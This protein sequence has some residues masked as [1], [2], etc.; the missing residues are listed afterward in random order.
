M[1]RMLAISVSEIS[2]LRPQCPLLATQKHC[3]FKIAFFNHSSKFYNPIWA[4][5]RV[6]FVC[7]LPSCYTRAPWASWRSLR[8]GTFWARAHGRT[9][10]LPQS[11]PA[12]GHP[13]T[14]SEKKN[15]RQDEDKDTNVCIRIFRI[16]QNTRAALIM[17][18]DVSLILL[19][20]YYITEV[21]DK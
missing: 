17:K 15:R 8:S 9:S 19:Y 5:M 16:F 18:S 7:E 14:S 4:H 3:T 21:K 2:N 1:I 13:S 20:C 11:Q 6:V 12:E 10:K